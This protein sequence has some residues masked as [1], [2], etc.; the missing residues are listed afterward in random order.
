MSYPTE[1]TTS[2]GEKI[3]LP[4]LSGRIEQAI[5]KAIGNLL[6]EAPEVLKLWTDVR[7]GLSVNN[8]NPAV[9]Q[10]AMSKLML[11]APDEVTNVVAVIV[12]KDTDWVLDN[13]SMS[14]DYIAVILPVFNEL[15]GR[16]TVSLDLMITQ[17]GLDEMLEDTEVVEDD[18][19]AEA[20]G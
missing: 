14:S 5:L 15:S 2:F 9:L 6:R 8:I 12:G 17:L 10:G 1:Y 3:E 18:A 13:L 11:M 16:L 19:A 4:R 7:K 20:E